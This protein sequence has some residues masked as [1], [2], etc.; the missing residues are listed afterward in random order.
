MCWHRQV[1][2]I[3]TIAEGLVE[4]PKV[5]WSSCLPHTG[6]VRFIQAYRSPSDAAERSSSTT[7]NRPGA[8][9]WLTLV[10]LLQACQLC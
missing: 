7:W 3:V 5:C 6:Q 4:D 9:F 8:S 1:Q 10:Q 2:A